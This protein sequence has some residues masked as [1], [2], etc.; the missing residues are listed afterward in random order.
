[1]ALV[2]APALTTIVGHDENGNE[3]REAKPKWGE[4]MTAI[5]VTV[6][7]VLLGMGWQW[8]INKFG[9]LHDKAKI[10]RESHARKRETGEADLIESGRGTPTT[11]DAFAINSSAAKPRPT[12]ERAPLV[13]SRSYGSY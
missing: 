11:Q 1:V 7:L 10:D 2:I 13:A 3:I 6:V 12:T 5:G 8:Y 9:Q 4:W